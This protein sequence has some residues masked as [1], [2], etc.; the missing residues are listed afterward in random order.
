M[1]AGFSGPVTFSYIYQNT[2]TAVT[3]LDSTVPFHTLTNAVNTGQSQTLQVTANFANVQSAQCTI[4]VFPF[5]GKYYAF[6]KAFYTILSIW[7]LQYSAG[8]SLAYLMCH[9]ST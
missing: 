5:G 6:S 4:Q 1:T 9:Q 2:G 8:N 3:L 7:C